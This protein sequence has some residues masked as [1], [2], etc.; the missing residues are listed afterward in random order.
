MG[1][2][3]SGLTRGLIPVVWPPGACTRIARIG[4]VNNSISAVQYFLNR[5]FYPDV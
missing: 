5:E 2:L 3:Q 1:A 4:T